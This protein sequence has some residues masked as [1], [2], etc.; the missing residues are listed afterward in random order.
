M[1][2]H[3]SLF[4]LTQL[5]E[6]SRII[7]TTQT[8]STQNYS[9]IIYSTQRLDTRL[10]NEILNF[11]DMIFDFGTQLNIKKEYTCNI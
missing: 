1:E 9:R 10:I 5:N 6:Y 11:K 2:A 3:L 7:K 4:K 8:Y